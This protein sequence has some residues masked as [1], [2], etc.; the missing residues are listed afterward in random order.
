MYPLA[1]EFT[2]HEGGQNPPVQYL[3]LTRRVGINCM[4]SDILW[5]FVGPRSGDDSRFRD[6]NTWPVQVSVAGLKAGTYADTFRCG[7][8]DYV[9][10][11]G[12][13]TVGITLTVTP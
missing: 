2:A 4:H 10:E 5:Y 11:H 13:D 7:S 9:V 8:M 6:E 1:F 3:H 12:L